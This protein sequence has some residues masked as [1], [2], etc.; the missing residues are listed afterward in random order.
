MNP[1]CS[2]S[3]DGIWT[4]GLTRP[5]GYEALVVWSVTGNKSYTPNARFKKIDDLSG[6]TSAITGGKVSIGFKPVLLHK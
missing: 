1:L 2:S 3:G 4:C 5:N 6:N